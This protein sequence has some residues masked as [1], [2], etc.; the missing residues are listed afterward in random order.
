[1]V[2]QAEGCGKSEKKSGYCGA[3]YQ[4]KWKYGDPLGGRQPNARCQAPGCGAAPRSRTASYCEM[5]YMRVR[6]NGSFDRMPATPVLEHTGGY[7][8]VYALGHPLATSG[9]NHVYEHRVVFHS[10]HGAGPFNCH[11]CG[12]VVR[13]SD[14][15]V[16]HLNDRRDDNAPANLVASCPTCNQ[17]RGQHKAIATRRER[18]ARWIEFGGERLTIS[19]WARRLGIASTSLSARI[20]AGWPIDRALTEPRGKFGP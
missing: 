9:H 7:R 18:H 19:D 20:K 11:H 17:H 5:H 15:H 4:R 10:L 1:M 14:M 8:L 13:W 3:H 6:R 16:D 2:C 12:I